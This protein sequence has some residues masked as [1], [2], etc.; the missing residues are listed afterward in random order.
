MD[1]AHRR[2]HDLPNG[3]S[4]GLTASFVKQVPTGTALPKDGRVQMYPCYSFE[5]HLV[6]VAFDPILARPEI[7]RYVIGP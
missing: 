6:L 7:R 2:F 4:P 3:T 5:F 1:I